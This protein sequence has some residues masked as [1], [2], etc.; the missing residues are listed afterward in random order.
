MEAEAEVS[1]RIQEV[2]ERANVAVGFVRRLVAVG[3][4]PGEEAGLGPREVR[5]TRLLQ[6]WEAAGLSVETIVGLVDGGAMSLAFLDAPVMATPE[7]LDRSYQELAA[8]RGVSPRFL[9]AVHQALGFA[10]P[11]PADRQSA[12]DRRRHPGVR[13]PGRVASADL[14]DPAHLGHDRSP[15]PSPRR[16]QTAGV[17]YGRGKLI[18]PVCRGGQYPGRDAVMFAGGT[19]SVDGRERCSSTSVPIPS[20]R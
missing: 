1:Y 9:Q 19:V 8:G 20:P 18:A 6:A 3:A 15:R 10:P 17:R 5:R 4:L 11:E 7:R 14:S 13:R 2:A 12:G 16:G